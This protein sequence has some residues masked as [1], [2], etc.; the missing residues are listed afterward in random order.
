MI[1]TIKSGNTNCYLIKMGNKYALIDAGTALDKDFLSK[2]QV[3]VSLN[4]IEIVVLTHGHYDHIGHAAKLQK[5]Y[6]SKIVIHQKDFDK[7]ANGTMDFPKARGL[8]SNCIRSNTLKEMERAKFIPFNADIIISSQERLAQYTQIE[9]VELPGHTPGSIGVMFND[10]LFAGDLVMNMPIPTK[11]WFAEDFEVLTKSIER[12]KK[13]NIK[14]IYPGHG[15]SFSAKW[16]M[17]I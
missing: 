12:I 11:S 4:Q 9:I 7:A 1:Q 8:L 5:D 15:T 14:R 17:H 2:L 13:L 16:I 6:G 3:V 10:N